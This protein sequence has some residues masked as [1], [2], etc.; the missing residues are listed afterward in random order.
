[1]R[2]TKTKTGGNTRMKKSLLV[3]LSMMLVLSFTLTACGGGQ[4]TEEG[5]QEGNNEQQAEQQTYHWRFVT[6]ELDG[7]V[8]PPPSNIKKIHSNTAIYLEW[9]HHTFSAGKGIFNSVHSI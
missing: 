3:L 8:S 4:E 6:E 9:K 5:Q 7:Q 1:M 2:Y